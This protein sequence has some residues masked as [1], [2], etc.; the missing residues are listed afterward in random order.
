MLEDEEERLVR[1]KAIL[2]KLGDSVEFRHWR[3][4]Q[5]FIEG[6]KSAGR[7]PA[8]I[9]LDHDLFTDHPDD[10]DPGDGRDV[11]EFLAAQTPCCHSIIHSSN[12][13]AADSRMERR[14]YRA[15]RSRLG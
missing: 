13:P 1:F 7:T 14:M 11:A 3:T 15:A 12:A 8:L 10:P 2:S 5:D 9:C 6:F 4:A